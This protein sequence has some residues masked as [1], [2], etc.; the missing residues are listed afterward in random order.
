MKK[1]GEKAKLASLSLTN[2][3][4]SKKNSV[5]KQFSKYLKT[6]EKLILKANKKDLI[7]AKSKK[8]RESMIDRLKLNRE[9]IKQI[10]K[11][12]DKIVKFKDP[13]GKTLSS[14][15]RPNGLVIK[16]ISIPIGI[17]G[18]IYESRPNV[19]SD[20]SALCFKSGNV[21][22]LRGGSEA[23]NSKKI[24]AKLFRKALNLV[25]GDEN[26]VQL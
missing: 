16:K 25:K 26:C 12:I 1:I 13:I 18:V 11:S 23:F 14:W 15:K 21:V 3:N 9:K 19:T 20:V 5:L 22:I 7:N 8:I 10:R 17:I 24:L 4:I 6:N 2:L